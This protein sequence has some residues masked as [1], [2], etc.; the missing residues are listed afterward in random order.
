MSRRLGISQKV[1]QLVRYSPSVHL[2]GIREKDYYC[3]E[4]ERACNVEFVFVAEFSGQAVLRQ[5]VQ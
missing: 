5:V 4:R 1:Q 2:E 3:C